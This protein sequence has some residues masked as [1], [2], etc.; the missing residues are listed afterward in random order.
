[1]EDYFEKTGAMFYA[2]EKC[3]DVKPDSNY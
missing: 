2:G 3:E 1:M